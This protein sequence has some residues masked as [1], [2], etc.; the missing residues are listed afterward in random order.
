MSGVTDVFLS[1]GRLEIQRDRPWSNKVR[2]WGGMSIKQD[3]P[4]TGDSPAV[5]SKV[6]TG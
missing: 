6:V 3:A 5:R 4:R 2:D 1:R